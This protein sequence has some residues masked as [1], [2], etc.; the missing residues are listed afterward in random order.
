MVGAN[1][2]PS[3]DCWQ[4]Q[5]RKSILAGLELTASDRIGEGSHCVVV[6]REPTPQGDHRLAFVSLQIVIEM[7]V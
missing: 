5:E 4:T 1:P 2:Q 7:D 3:A 6:G